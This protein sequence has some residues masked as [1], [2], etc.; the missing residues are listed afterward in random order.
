MCHIFSVFINIGAFTGI[1]TK[2]GSETLVGRIPLYALR[3]DKSLPKELMRAL[4]E[5]VNR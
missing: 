4:Q 5:K 2:V 3:T 1:V